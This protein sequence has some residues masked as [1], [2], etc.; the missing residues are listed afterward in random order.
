MSM[1]PLQSWATVLLLIVFAVALAVI[2][3]DLNARLDRVAERVK[4]RR[5]GH[6]AA[7]A[8]SMERHPAAGQSRV[9]S[10]VVHIGSAPSVR[11]TGRPHLVVLDG[12]ADR[13]ASR[14][15]PRLYDHEVDGL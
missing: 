8:S 1:T 3:T 7:I 4:Q 14:P 6:A 9:A 13:S 12:G 15:Q 5:A 11:A 10:N 2:F